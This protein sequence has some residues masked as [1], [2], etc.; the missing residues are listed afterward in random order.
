MTCPCKEAYERAAKV[1]DTHAGAAL[2]GNH[3]I[4][5]AMATRCAVA[6]RALPPCGRCSTHQWVPR[7]LT[8]EQ[9]LAAMSAHRKWEHSNQDFSGGYWNAIYKA[10]LAAKEEGK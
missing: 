10:M 4:T 1:C 7:E 9:T 2:S 5:Y 3:E 8:P 6:I